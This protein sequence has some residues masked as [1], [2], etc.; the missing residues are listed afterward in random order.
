MLLLGKYGIGEER[1]LAMTEPEI[2]GWL[3]AHKA[4]QTAAL[5]RTK[6]ASRGQYV[7]T[8]TTH[9]QSLRRKPKR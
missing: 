4:L 6:Q 8:Q 2:I 5:N 9:I 1:V 3:D 7:Q